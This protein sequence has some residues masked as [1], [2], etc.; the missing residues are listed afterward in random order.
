MSNI[1]KSLGIG[2]LKENNSTA[3]IEKQ[4]DVIQDGVQIKA[5][6]SIIGM[7]NTVEK[8]GDFNKATVSI[9]KLA[10]GSEYTS[11]V[12]TDGVNIAKYTKYASTISDVSTSYDITSLSVKAGIVGK[13]FKKV[14][15]IKALQQDI[16]S[17]CKVATFTMNVGDTAIGV[18]QTGEVDGVV[19]RAWKTTKIGGTL[20][21]YLI[22]YDD[23]K[24]KIGV[25]G[26]EKKGWKVVTTLLE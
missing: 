17:V 23:T 6:S 15:S 22:S 18:V 20:D 12:A 9:Q 24:N 21:R 3:M 13:G 26:I 10:V 25:G 7:E 4:I 5:S 2:V 8:I 19:N 16:S 14:D 11:V 1:S